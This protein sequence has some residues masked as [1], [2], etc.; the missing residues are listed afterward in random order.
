MMA[1]SE[2]RFGQTAKTLAAAL[3]VWLLAGCSGLAAPTVAASA[4]AEPPTIAT[5]AASP[6]VKPEDGNV[7]VNEAIGVS[8]VLPDGWSVAGPFRVEADGL[9]YDAYSVGLE[10]SASGGPGLSRI[11]VGDSSSMTLDAFALQQCKTCPEHPIED[12]TLDG[13]PARRLTIGGGG[14]PFTVEWT[15]VELGSRTVGF[16]LRDP[17]TLAPLPDILATVRLQGP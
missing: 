17:D 5:D 9:T 11:V 4:T 7:Y 6:T 16:S 1:I 15:F 14:V 10:P 3:A 12:T 13:R 2:F 8:M